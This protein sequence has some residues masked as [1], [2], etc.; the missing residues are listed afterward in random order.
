ML[1]GAAKIMDN[2]PMSMDTSKLFSLVASGDNARLSRN[3]HRQF[4]TALWSTYYSKDDP[5]ISI[6]PIAMGADKQ[7]VRYI[8]RVINTDLGRVMREA[9]YLMKKWAVGTEK[10]PIPGFRDVDTISGGGRI[11]FADAFRRFWFVPEDMTFKG[12]D[13]M[14]LFDH[15]RMTVKTE[16]LGSGKKGRALEGDRIFARFF[17]DHYDEIA[18]KY[19]IFK[20][21]FEYAKLVSLAK[22][23]KQQGVP[24]HWFLMA[25]LDDVI[26]EDSVGSVNTLSKGSKYLKDARIEGGVE[27]NGRYVLDASASAAIQ[28]ALSRID[29]PRKDS[30]RTVP[31]TARPVV[32]HDHGTFT[33]EKQVFSI[34][35]QHSATSGIDRRGIRYQTDVAIRQGR[36]P[37]LELVRYFRPSTHGVYSKGEFGN[38]WHLLR[39]YRIVPVGKPTVP[40]LNVLIPAKVA[41][42]NLVTGQDE[43]LTFDDK[44]YKLAGYRPAD[45]ASSRLVGLFWTVAGGMRLVDKLGNEFWFNEGLMLS[46]MHFSDEFGMQFEYGYEEAGRKTYGRVPYRLEPEGKGVT[47]DIVTY[48]PDGK[49]R[50]LPD[51]LRLTDSVSGGTKL[52]RFG[53]NDAGLL[54]YI[55]DAPNPLDREFIALRGDGVHILVNANGS[56]VWFNQ[57]LEFLKWRPLLV[58]AVIQGAYKWKAEIKDIEFVPNHTAQLDYEFADGAFRVAGASVLKQGLSTAIHRIAYRYAE[59]SMLASASTR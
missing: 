26:T 22:Y 9:D 48:G 57:Q 3:A 44:K 31:G 16:I 59:D 21:L 50:P 6:D 33:V 35:P 45:M 51:K 47:H 4:V 36:E 40:F 5:G 30:P 7:L 55:Y 41:V 18:A 17:T 42:R 38:G 15:G 46:E 25:H 10:P 43:I 23:L 37:G 53:E 52:F 49:K 32:P 54:G 39:P 8:G 20:D 29:Q 56:E 2:K 11:T 58:K 1:S 28:R 14:F 13:G 19:P 27:M 34:V 24:L 12:S